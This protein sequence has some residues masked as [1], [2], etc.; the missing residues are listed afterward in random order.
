MS[1]TRTNGSREETELDEVNPDK[2]T[3]VDKNEGLD[4]ILPELGVTSETQRRTPCT[5]YVGT[6]QG[7]PFARVKYDITGDTLCTCEV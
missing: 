5:C 2:K 4:E 1:L 3:S 6:L 7:A